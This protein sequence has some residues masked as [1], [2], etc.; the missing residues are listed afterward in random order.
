[1]F[2]FNEKSSFFYKPKGKN[3]GSLMKTKDYD[4]TQLSLNF[5]LK[6]NTNT[7]SVSFTSIFD[8]YMD[9]SSYDADFLINSENAK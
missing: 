9:L 2:H 6:D 5:F 4:D 8:S 1:M 3:F 7:I